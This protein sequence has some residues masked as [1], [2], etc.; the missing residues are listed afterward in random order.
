L[1]GKGSFLSICQRKK[2]EKMKRIRFLDLLVM[3]M[4]VMSL[5]GLPSGHA[6]AGGGTLTVTTVADG[7]DA[8]PGDLACATLGG[9]CTLRA[10][11]Q[12]ANA[13]AGPQSIYFNLPGSGIHSMS[14][15]LGPLPA[16]TDTL[17]LD[18]STQ[19]SCSVPC[20]VLSGAVVGGSNTGLALNSN[21]NTVTGL[22]ITSWGF[23]GI[24]INGD[25]NIVEGC[26]IGFWPDNP[27]S[28]PNAYGVEIRGSNNQVGG[29]TA[30]A[31]NVISGNTYSGIAIGRSGGTPSGNLI[32]GNYIGTNAAGTAALPNGES[33]IIVY[34]VASNTRI[35]GATAATRNVISGN[36]WRG[37]DSGAPGTRILGNFIGTTKSGT[38][39]LGNSLGG[40][41]F[42]GGTAI[43]GG[44]TAGGSNIIAFNG[45]DGVGVY[46]ASTRVNLRRNSIHS[47]SGLGID[48]WND[49]VTL[50]DTL[51]VDTGPNGLQNFPIITS[52][53]SATHTLTATLR[54]VTGQTYRLDFYSSPAGTCDPTHYG[55]GKKWL[56]TVNV[57]TNVNGV[58][59]GS[60]TTAYPFAVGQVITA[61]ATDTAG[62]TS[63]FSYCRTAG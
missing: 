28:L 47:N 2:G 9:V 57:T 6:S 35:G 8:N 51:D 24:A 17:M 62:N 11:I 22:I 48:L 32:Y 13:L 23:D 61:T 46:G 10:A 20:I 52:P 34:Y 3:A 44:G 59:S 37:V 30:A 19:P 40:I 27:S 55:E 58:W 12:E 25:G 56:G 7:N 16:I 29:S 1:N 53:V 60:V 42:D 5:V 36:A 39:A 41:Y 4:L 49:G 54:S 15:T 33:G 50:N 31:R 26:D 18:G 21:M 45:G 14:I 43:V 63:E 38:A